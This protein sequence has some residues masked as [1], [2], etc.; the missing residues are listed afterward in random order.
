MVPRNTNIF[1][2]KILLTKLSFFNAA[3]EI[4]N[5]LNKKFR[6]ISPLLFKNKE[7]EIIIKSEISLI[8]NL[9]FSYIK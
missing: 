6:S 1:N 7:T 4:I 8:L 5:T 2:D 9:I 3:I